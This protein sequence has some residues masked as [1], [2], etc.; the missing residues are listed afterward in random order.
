MLKCDLGSH[1]DVQKG[2]ALERIAEGGLDKGLK[3]APRD[4]LPPL[5]PVPAELDKDGKPKPSS[6][7]PRAEEIEE[8]F[9]GRYAQVLD[10]KPVQPLP[11]TKV[12]DGLEYNDRHVPLAQRECV[13]I[14]LPLIPNK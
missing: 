10:A 1:S 3:I 13:A 11:T 2:S 8:R 12:K 5:E 6:R 9:R 7:T 14:Y 4:T